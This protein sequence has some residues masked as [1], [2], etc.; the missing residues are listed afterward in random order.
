MLAIQAPSAR[1]SPSPNTKKVFKAKN[2]DEQV[3]PASFM[4]NPI[5]FNTVDENNYQGGIG[6]SEIPDAGE[7]L[8]YTDIKSTLKSKADAMLPFFGE[9]CTVKCFHRNWQY[10]QEGVTK[11]IEQIPAVFEK[12][13]EENN[14]QQVNSA[15]LSTIVEIFKDKVQ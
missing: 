14:I 5:D 12:G 13:K 4:Q 3:V 15:V 11:F 6:G 1:G 10:R 8:R 7:G 9:E 2:V